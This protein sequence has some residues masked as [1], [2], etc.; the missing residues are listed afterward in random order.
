[1]EQ[2]PIRGSWLLMQHFLVQMAFLY[3]L[4]ITDA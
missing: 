4:S 1:M 3:K 2:M